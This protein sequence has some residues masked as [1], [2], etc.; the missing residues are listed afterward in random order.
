MKA[1]TLLIPCLLPLTVVALDYE[2]GHPPSLQG[3][4]HWVEA[5]KTEVKREFQNTTAR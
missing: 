3:F 4:I 1:F 2:R 5:A